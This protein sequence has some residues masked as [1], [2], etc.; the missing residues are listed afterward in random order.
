[1]QEYTDRCNTSSQHLLEHGG[2]CTD[3]LKRREWALSNTSLIFTSPEGWLDDQNPR[4]IVSAWKEGALCG[5]MHH[6]SSVSVYCD[7]LS[8]ASWQ[9]QAVKLISAFFSC[10]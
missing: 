8:A 3:L 4:T 5:R 10:T 2:V 6:A 7:F 9:C 1:M